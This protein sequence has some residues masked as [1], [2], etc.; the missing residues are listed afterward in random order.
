MSNAFISMP[1]KPSSNEHIGSVIPPILC[2][3]LGDVFS[4]YKS[5]KIITINL[6][7]SYE[8]REKYLKKHLSG[9][10]KFDV[11][12]DMILYDIDFCS[13]VLDSIRNM[14]DV[15]IIK[16]AN[17]RILRCHCGRVELSQKG[18]RIK[19][20]ASLYSVCAGS[21]I[22][23]YCKSVCREYNEKVLYI[24]IDNDKI[25]ETL[26]S[27]I[28]LSKCVNGK[29]KDLQNSR[30]IISKTRNT[31][32][33]INYKGNNYFIDVDFIWMN[34]FRFINADKKILISGNKQSLKLFYINYIYSIYDKDKINFIMHPILNNVSTDIFEINN[35]PLAKKLSI[36]FNL[37]WNRESCCWNNQ[38][39]KYVN[40]LSL[41]QLEE[42]YSA[43][44]SVAKS[45]VPERDSLN[46]QID[47][48]LKEG[49]NLQ[50]I[51]KLIKK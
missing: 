49:T 39:E 7:H 14:L 31:G 19:N 11:N 2:D 51:K 20:N 32:Y 4:D 12:Q 28:F 25:N 13:K 50:K 9:I 8:N 37:S 27:P 3:Y 36:M 43:M 26:I 45:I 6:L 18:I 16:E 34:M 44:V 40:S 48:I 41:V 23:N 29:S 17:E 42:F 24:S 47:L 1:I 15:G 46:N 5:E 33:S 38:I 30:F 21:L 35:Y 10:E 22:C